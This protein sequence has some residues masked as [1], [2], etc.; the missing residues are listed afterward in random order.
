MFS[1]SPASI[2]VAAAEAPC[3]AQPPADSVALIEYTPTARPRLEAFIARRFR[4]VYDAEVRHFMP[5]L[6][7]LHD[8]RGE[9]VA[10][11]GLRS[12]QAQRLFLEHYLD[13]PVEV[14][15]RRQFGLEA[16]REE[17]V[18][19]GNLAGASQGALRRLIPAL[20]E[21]LHDDGFR[22]LA[23]TGA[24]HLCNGFARLGLPLHVVAPAQP[25]RLPA[26]ERALWGRYYDR[27][28]AVM[29]GD[30]TSGQRTLQRLARSPR[31]LSAQLAP[32][33]RVGS[34]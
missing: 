10:A 26:S 7:G 32:I 28:P 27:Q 15:V 11:F 20:T 22:W 31:A 2:D 30:I 21:R 17:I 18:E 25:E 3:A 14:C 29:L 33:A 23:F 5:R 8:G 19:V 6:F 9:L 4:E 24:A 12:A 16:S 1:P 13:E 34:P